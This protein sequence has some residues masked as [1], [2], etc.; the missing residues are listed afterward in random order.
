MV[1]EIRASGLGRLSGGYNTL[2]REREP[3]RRTANGRRAMLDNRANEI[4]VDGQE[5]LGYGDGIGQ[6]AMAV[7]VWL[8]LFL[9]RPWPQSSYF[10]SRCSS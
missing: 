8:E 5:L 9:S 3:G 7:R 1:L 2:A 4:I 6:H 10:G